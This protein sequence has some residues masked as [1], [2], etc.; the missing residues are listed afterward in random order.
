MASFTLTVNGKPVNVD[1]DPDTPLLW[2]IR[3]SL[4]LT[5]TKYSCGTGVCGS[6]TVV[7]DGEAVRSCNIMMKDVVG[8]SVTTIE[9][10]AANPNNPVIRSWIE[11]DVSECGYC[12]PGQIMTAAALLSKNPR[13]STADITT[14]FAGSLCRCGTYSRITKAVQRAASKGGPFR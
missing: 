4:G 6:C 8:R 13:P 5:G 14:A 3:D 10:L 1:V 2:V 11:E 9:G 7:I 12:Q